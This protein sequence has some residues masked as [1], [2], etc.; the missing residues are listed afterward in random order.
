M[1]LACGSAWL[2]GR[3]LSWSLD[4]RDTARQGRPRDG[5]KSSPTRRVPTVET[6][7]W[8]GASMLRRLA[9]LLL[10]ACGQAATRSQIRDALAKAL[11]ATWGSSGRGHPGVVH[12]GVMRGNDPVSCRAD[13]ASCSAGVTIAVAAGGVPDVYSAITHYAV[14]RDMAPLSTLLAAGHSPDVAMVIHGQMFVTP[15]MLA[16]VLGETE[17]MLLLLEHGADVSL[18]DAS[19]ASALTYACGTFFKAEAAPSRKVEGQPP[20]A[21]KA[22]H[23]ALARN[24]VQILVDFGAELGEEPRGG[25]ASWSAYR[26]LVATAKDTD[27]QVAG[28]PT[29]YHHSQRPGS[30]TAARHGHTA[31]LRRLL[32]R[33]MTP[34]AR[35]DEGSTL[36]MIASFDSQDK[37]VQVKANPNPHPNPN[38]KLSL[39]LTSSCSAAV[40]TRRSLT[41]TVVPP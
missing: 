32:E 34:D 31:V 4:W 10:V 20:E 35:D 23:L 6:R 11:R 15:L 25:L 40:P 8:A 22:A 27:G 14:E 3:R 30:V 21:V 36:L 24:R 5:A 19:A 39:T 12:D 17:L 26:D 28:I 1:A 16:S 18:T 33:G 41:T 38:P 29:A 13:P 9:M 7:G 2:G 37:I